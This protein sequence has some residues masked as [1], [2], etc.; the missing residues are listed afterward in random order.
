MSFVDDKNYKSLHPM[1]R[2][3][4]SRTF[5]L[6]VGDKQPILNKGMS[7]SHMRRCLSVVGLYLIITIVNCEDLI[8]TIKPLMHVLPR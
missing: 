7:Q 4:K 8:K 1:S 6:S 3:I 5:I 2:P